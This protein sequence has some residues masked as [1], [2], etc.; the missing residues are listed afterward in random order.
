MAKMPLLVRIGRW[1]P[2]LV[3]GTVAPADAASATVAAHNFVLSDTG[4][5]AGQIER[6]LMSG[7]TPAR[8][9]PTVG[10]GSRDGGAGRAG[11]RR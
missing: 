6:G 5:R 2:V 11:G 4:K 10:G 9:L 3:L 7:Q 8:P 1:R